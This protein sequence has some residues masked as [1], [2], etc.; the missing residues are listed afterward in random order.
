MISRFNTRG[1]TPVPRQKCCGDLPRP[2]RVER[3]TAWMKRQ[4]A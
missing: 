2:Y 3:R 1:P 4:S